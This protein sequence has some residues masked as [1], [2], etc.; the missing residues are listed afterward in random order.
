MIPVD[1]R[2]TR[3]MYESKMGLKPTTDEPFTLVGSGCWPM[4]TCLILPAKWGDFGWSSLQMAVYGL[5]LEQR[6]EPYC[7]FCSIWGRHTLDCEEK[8][9]FQFHLSCRR[10]PRLQAPP[11]GAPWTKLKVSLAVL[12]V[13]SAALPCLLYYSL[14]YWAI[15]CVQ[16][17]N[18][19]NTSY[20]KSFKLWI[21][22]SAQSG[23]AA[24]VWNPFVH[25]DVSHLGVLYLNLTQ[26]SGGVKRKILVLDLDETLIH[27]HHD[28]VLRPSVRPGTPPDFILKVWP[29]LDTHTHL[30]QRS[31][32]Q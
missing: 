16:I 4:R 9:L 28:G 1:G 21:P 19:T 12:S 8:F 7:V 14:Y 23:S 22:V 3:N 32:Y 30:R 5:I 20:L 31:R 11:P 13:T 6:S 17:K 18:T 10:W 29:P 25:I 15:S 2:I 26:T 27:S 24:H